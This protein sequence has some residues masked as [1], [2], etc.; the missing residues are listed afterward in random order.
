METR[1]FLKVVALCLVM[2]L[3]AKAEPVSSTYY[4]RWQAAAALALTS[5]SSAQAERALDD[6]AESGAG[7]PEAERPAA[8]QFLHAAIY[9]AARLPATNT[10]HIFSADMAARRASFFD[11]LERLPWS[12]GRRAVWNGLQRDL[13]DNGI[14]Y[15]SAMLR[16]PGFLELCREERATPEQFSALIAA[17]SSA[18][19][20]LLDAL[21]L[22][23]SLYPRQSEQWRALFIARLS[24]ERDPEFLSVL[25]AGLDAEHWRQFPKLQAPCRSA[26]SEHFLEHISAA[27]WPMLDQ[28]LLPAMAR[29]GRAPL[30]V[31]EQKLAA[32]LAAA[33]EDTSIRGCLDA[34]VKKHATPRE[35]FAAIAPLL[36]A[37]QSLFCLLHLPTN[38][39]M[40][41]L[42]RD[43]R[44]RDAACR[45]LKNFLMPERESEWDVR[46]ADLLPFYYQT[47][48]R[49]VQ[50][51][52]YL[53][54]VRPIIGA[55]LSQDFDQDRAANPVR[56]QMTSALAAP[57]GY[58]APRHSLDLAV[59]FQEGLDWEAGI[60]LT[61]GT[62]P[63]YR[64]VAES[65]LAL[66]P[67]WLDDD[68]SRH[69][70][71]SYAAA[72]ARWTDWML[73]GGIKRP[74]TLRF[75]VPEVDSALREVARTW[76]ETRNR[77]KLRQ[78]EADLQT[79]FASVAEELSVAAEDF[80]RKGG[81]YDAG[82]ARRE[83]LVQ[84]V[85]LTLTV[86]A[87]IEDTSQLETVLDVMRSRIF[88]LPT[89]GAAPMRVRPISVLWEEVELFRMLDDDLA[90]C[91]QGLAQAPDVTR[92]LRD[93]L[94]GFVAR[95]HYEVQLGLLAT[96][97]FLARLYD[98]DEHLTPFR[99]LLHG[100][101]VSNPSVLSGE[102]TRE[103]FIKLAE[104]LDRSPFLNAGAGL[105]EL[106]N[107]YRARLEMSFWRNPL[108]CGL[109]ANVGLAALFQLLRDE[110]LPSTADVPLAE[111]DDWP[112]PVF[113]PVLDA[114]QAGLAAGPER[115]LIREVRYNDSGRV[116][117]AELDDLHEY[118]RRAD[119]L[120]RAQE[121]LSFPCV[122][123]DGSPMD[124]PDTL[125]LAW[126]RTAVSSRLSG[127]LPA[128][129][130]PSGIVPCRRLDG[131]RRAEL[132][133]VALKHARTLDDSIAAAECAV[134]LP[135]SP[136]NAANP[137]RLAE[138]DEIRRAAFKKLQAAMEAEAYSERTTDGL[139]A[140]LRLE[141]CLHG[142]GQMLGA[143]QAAG[144][145]SSRLADDGRLRLL[146]EQWSLQSRFPVSAAVERCKEHELPSLECR[147]CRDTVAAALDVR[148][149]E[150]EDLRRFCVAQTG[151]APTAAP[152]DRWEAIAQLAV[153]LR[154]LDNVAEEIA[155]I[156]PDTVKSAWYLSS[157]VRRAMGAIPSHWTVS[158]SW[159]KLIEP[160][161]PLASAMVRVARF[162]A[163]TFSEMLP[164]HGNISQ[165]DLLGDAAGRPANGDALAV[166]SMLD[167]E[168]KSFLLDVAALERRLPTAS[169]SGAGFAAPVGTLS[170]R[171]LVAVH[172]AMQPL[173]ALGI[174]THGTN[175]VQGGDT[176]MQ[177]VAEGRQYAEMYFDPDLIM[178]TGGSFT[179][180]PHS[181]LDEALRS[182]DLLMAAADPVNGDEFVYNTWFGDLRRT[183]GGTGGNLSD[184]YNLDTF[185][186]AASAMLDD[187]RYE[188]VGS[189]PL[190]AMA[191]TF[192]GELSA[193]LSSVGGA[194]MGR[195]FTAVRTPMVLTAIAER[196]ADRLGLYRPE[197][198]DGLA[199][200]EGQQREAY[201][202]FCRRCL[203]D[204]GAGRPVF[205]MVMREPLVSGFAAGLA[206]EIAGAANGLE[207]ARAGFTALFDP[208]A[209]PDAVT[210]LH[211]GGLIG[212]YR[213]AL[214]MNAADNPG[215]WF[216]GDFSQAY[217]QLVSEI[218]WHGAWGGD[219][220]DDTALT[221]SH[222]WRLDENGRVY[223]KAAVPDD[224]ST[225]AA[226]H[227]AEI[228][229]N[230]AWRAACAERYAE[231]PFIR[232][233][234]GGRPL[235]PAPENTLP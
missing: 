109:N 122:R 24:D 195:G 189:A 65:L 131:A 193:W 208:Y 92:E 224:P 136:Q 102:A 112:T 169:S 90:G 88:E 75:N 54:V 14:W 162:Y 46:L 113:L 234:F 97:G 63:N 74:T 7:L 196:I 211:S 212:L 233:F 80:R 37:H 227:T 223:I 48:S 101:P 50:D 61:D 36:A 177:F 182:W 210:E 94:R 64:F 20:G 40:D 84:A 183:I 32:A 202:G 2:A 44:N 231:V 115:V 23:Q 128:L 146:V 119:Y 194:V 91:I 143:W 103:S 228:R 83:R 219:A 34:L 30:G 87:L 15:D 129:T 150:L 235:P 56:R 58:L 68:A 93:M 133:R 42:N 35:T 163:V 154:R 149:D 49:R 191:T 159:T 27:K 72:L 10:M 218:Y 139:I 229:A 141:V 22:A 187:T 100:E 33:P 164:I 77:F 170:P 232:R 203:F 12:G 165:A 201:A 184:Q 198:L 157:Q 11:V 127:E 178:E 114:L 117:S 25:F 153:F 213:R 98:M 13:V 41:T 132:C 118:V 110:T 51:D 200:L 174:W 19:T 216:A 214:A 108:L 121:L 155:A 18:P 206:A 138:Y 47:A 55:R 142:R 151:A 168:I 167:A 188:T 215:Y 16:L 161:E 29:A 85:R 1:I 106:I 186:L 176:L 222:P 204:T 70:G 28:G 71:M 137:K 81:D 4:T 76:R 105:P 79:L 116:I 17:L 6:L 145:W 175:T 207:I 39:V 225:A 130:L 190:R 107:L 181:M 172:S 144:K 192:Q 209:P 160:E 205:P 53:T 99:R 26:I 43:Q 21:W 82:R 57:G 123:D 180:A 230:L 5:K 220:D 125:A 185:L 38:G 8:T 111:A 69:D 158:P 171:E 59:A 96:D 173:L 124:V 197:S 78:K 152:R 9:H 60:A 156:G 166:F 126:A 73:R 3:V 45:L 89:G 66:G 140:M 147:A 86:S 148:G 226:L 134:M 95:Y 199:A 135:N 217:M 62:A 120:L 67:R 52:L 104:L 179:L 221:V 31:W